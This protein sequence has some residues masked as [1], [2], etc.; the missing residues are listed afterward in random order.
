[1]RKCQKECF[2][3]DINEC[4]CILKFGRQEL[5]EF[6]I[7]TMLSERFELGLK[8][9]MR[10]N[11]MGIFHTFIIASVCCMALAGCGH[12]TPVVYVPDNQKTVQNQ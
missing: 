3:L 4:D 5:N 2:V 8:R 7:T 6:L 9:E 10:E 12:K 1:M 11:R